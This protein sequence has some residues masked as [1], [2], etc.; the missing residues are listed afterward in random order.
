MNKIFRYAS[1][2]ALI[3]VV[4]VTTGCAKTTSTKKRV[5]ALEAQVGVLTDEITRLDQQIQETRGAVGT[6]GS[7]YTGG[8]SV[9]ETSVY[10]TPSGFE[11]PSRDIQSALKGAGYYQGSVD[12]KIG[13]GTKDAIKAFQRDHGLNSDGVVGRQTWEKLKTYLSG[14]AG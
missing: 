3:A 4:F 14:S 1:F 6:S 5:N 13:P 2:A 12:G 8:R 11:L 9:A 7:S 10:R